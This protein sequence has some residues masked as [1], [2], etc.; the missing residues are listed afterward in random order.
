MH[1]I[2]VAAIALVAAA[3]PMAQ[4]AAAPANTLSAQ[5]KS[6]GWVL[7]FDGTN[8]GK[9]LRGFKKEAMPDAWKVEDGCLVLRGQ[10]GDIITKDQWDNFEFQ[11]DWNIAPGGNS[12]IMYRVTEDGT[13]PWETGQEMQVLDDAKHPDGKNRLTSAGS[14]YALYA[15]PEGVVKPAGE[16]NTA[17]IVAVGPKITYYLNGTKVVEFDMSSAEYKER[18]AKSKFA[19][20]PMFGTKTKGH[21][22]LQDHGDVVKYRN[23]KVRPLGADG[24]AAPAGGKTPATGSAPATGNAPVAKPATGAPGSGAPATGTP[25]A[26]S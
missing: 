17:R 12:G 16:W 25:K 18:L 1:W 22:A 9:S 5:E 6:D 10:G 19:S 20:M 11:V 14:C 13:Y 23:V 4:Q 21:I 15:A 24:K 2:P 7:L 3:A 8:A 26:G